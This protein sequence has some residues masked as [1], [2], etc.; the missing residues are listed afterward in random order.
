MPNQDATEHTSSGRHIIFDFDGV[1]GDTYAMNWQLVRELHPDVAEHT[2]RHDHHLGNVHEHNR[3]G[4]TADTAAEY[5]RRYNDALAV[6]HVAAAVPALEQLGERYCL[7]IVS[8]NCESAIRRVLG[9]AKVEPLFGLMLGK[10]ANESKVEKFRHLFVAEEFDA[11]ETVYVTDTLGDLHE[12]SK[13][14]MP[15]IAVT[16]GYHDLATLEQGN[17]T[18]IADNWQEVVE[19]IQTLVG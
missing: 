17:P 8:S 4:F 12:A 1:I 15:T 10:E 16:W 18:A 6:E 14:S 11:T 2:Y 13:V 7:H 19:H 3:V 9:D 5:Y